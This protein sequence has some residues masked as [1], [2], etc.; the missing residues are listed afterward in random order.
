MTNPLDSGALDRRGMAWLAT[1]HLC[2]DVCQGA[3][4]AMLPFLV[5]QRGYS[6]SAASA[7]VLAVSFSS[8]IV[9]PIFG[10]VSDRHSLSWLMPG[11]LILAGVGLGV[12]GFAHTYALTFLAVVLSG[13]GIA[14]YH[15][16]GSRYANYVSGPRRATGMSFFS[17]GGN[18]GF[19]LGPAL[20]TPA[21]LLLGLEGTAVVGAVPIAVGLMFAAQLVYLKRFRPAAGA[22]RAA[23]QSG[24]DRWGPF[25]RLGGVIAARSIVY[26]G[27]MTF[28]PLYFVHEL[29]RSK[30]TGNTA[31]TVMLAAGAAGTL[32]GGRAADRYGRRAVL[33]GSMAVLT[34]L[35]IA[36]LAAGPVLATMILAIIGAAA[37]S[38]FSVTVV[39][40]QEY[41]PHRIGIASGVT[42]GLA[43]GLGGI[44]AALLGVLADAEGIRTVMWVVAG[45][46]LLGLAITLTLPNPAP[47]G[48]QARGPRGLGRSTTRSAT[49]GHLS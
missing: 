8:S 7:L 12:S 19:A 21:V 28:V 1:G 10:Y 9:Q 32:I 42:L 45:L 13:L 20:L 2:V 4:P 16:E 33:V 25:A 26:F 46:P 24:I 39:M 48:G 38:T 34:P 29:G 18:A 22:T 31:L 11:G 40:G 17:V 35:I 30:A 47:L 5:S 23:V 44:A 3:V 37:I 14:A 36:F 15:P 49:G 43:I 6:L 27:L 41:L